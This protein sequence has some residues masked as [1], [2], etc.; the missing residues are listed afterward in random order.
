MRCPKTV[1]GVSGKPGRLDP[2][3]NRDHLAGMAKLYVR[4]TDEFICELH[5]FECMDEN[6]FVAVAA[7]GAVAQP[8][9]VKGVWIRIEDDSG[10]RF[11]GKLDGVAISG[12]GSASVTGTASPE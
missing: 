2:G 5:G 3:A 6:D 12:D 10:R 4:D 7:D 9:S 8:L 11:T 1:T